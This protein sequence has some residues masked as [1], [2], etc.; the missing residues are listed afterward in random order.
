MLP[1]G[2][3]EPPG[4]LA[5]VSALRHQSILFCVPSVMLGQYRDVCILTSVVCAL[6]KVLIQVFCNPRNVVVQLVRLQ[7]MLCGPS[8]SVVLHALAHNAP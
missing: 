4:V 2:S 8:Q 6:C 7:R 5:L 3:L 1:T